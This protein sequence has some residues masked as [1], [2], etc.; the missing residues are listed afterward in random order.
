VLQPTV[1]DVGEVVESIAP[2]LR[3]VI[4]E[5]IELLIVHGDSLS[6][7]IADRGQL[8]QVLMNLIVNARDAMPLGGTITVRTANVPLDE[9]RAGGGTSGRAVSLSVA[10][11]GTGMPDGVRERVFEPF[12]TTKDVGKGTGL[13][14]STVYGIVKQSGG[15]ID[16][17][18]TIGSGTTFTV[19]FPAATELEPS[20]LVLDT[21]AEVAGGTETILLVEDEEPVRLLATRTLE[22]RGY[23]VLAVGDPAD[24]LR[25]ADTVDVDAILTDIVMPRLSGPQLVAQLSARGRAPAVIYMSGYAD[26]ALSQFELDHRITFL[27]KPF[28]SI[29]L[30]RAVREAL[31]ARRDATTEAISAD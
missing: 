22:D 25:L 5:H 27:R 20:G 21:E 28:T 24:A 12:F 18:S 1:L 17:D 10:D 8:E 15:T 11:T 4:G 6:R 13:G 23:S 3:R 2:M 31:T 30:A 19:T 14:L 16:V 29:G 26:D 7:V 9:V